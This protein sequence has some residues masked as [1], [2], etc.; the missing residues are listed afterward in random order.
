M[1]FGEILKFI[2]SG[3]KAKR[4]CWEDGKFVELLEDPKT[5]KKS[6]VTPMIIENKVNDKL[7]RMGWIIHQ[8]DVLAEDWELLN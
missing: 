6:L 5:K 8:N 2:T 3:D 1:K 7:D 4:A